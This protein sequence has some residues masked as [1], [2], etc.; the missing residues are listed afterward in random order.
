MNRSK[1]PLPLI[2]AIA[3]STVAAILRP[4][5][6][7]AA[8]TAVPQRTITV[9]GEGEAKA[10]PDE[11]HL[12]AGVVSEAR[13]AADA[14]AA[15]TRAMNE[16]FA[17]LKRFGIPDKAIQTSEFSVE[18]QMQPERNG[19]SAAKISGYMVSN[20]VNVTVDLPKLGPALDAL[21]ASGANSLGSVAFAI[22]DPKPLLA[23]ARAKAIK[24]AMERAQSY[25]TAGGL[26]LGPILSVSEGGAEM[27]RPIYAARMMAAAPA[28]P[29]V[30]A[31][32]E[33]V[34]TNVTVTFEI[35]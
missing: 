17:T 20:T 30:A 7:A 31:G 9:S 8:D 27:P 13:K 19:N 1:N 11:A 16:V 6:A 35:R 34:S 28:P 26:A 29:P 18:P 32:E 23:R 2:V 21:V 14:L 4:S 5:M 10:V 22:R 33:S 25:A 3:L 24:D 12:S 15:N